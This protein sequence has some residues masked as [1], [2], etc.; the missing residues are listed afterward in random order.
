M[1]RRPPR[2][3]LDRSSAASDV[4]KRQGAEPGRAR[5]QHHRQSLGSRRRQRQLTGGSA[6]T[7]P[8]AVPP[9]GKVHSRTRMLEQPSV[10]QMPVSKRSTVEKVHIA[11]YQR[12]SVPRQSTCTTTDDGDGTLC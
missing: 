4:Y 9:V 12:P 3:T 5:Q 6:L 7:P 1:I 11:M 8:G 10:D 2:S